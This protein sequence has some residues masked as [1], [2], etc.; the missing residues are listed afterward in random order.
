MVPYIDTGDN[1]AFAFFLHSSVVQNFMFKKWIKGKEFILTYSYLHW[2]TIPLYYD[3]TVPAQAGT[4]IFIFLKVFLLTISPN[5]LK[6]IISSSIT[7]FWWFLAFSG[8]GS[9]LYFDIGYDNHIQMDNID[10]IRSYFIS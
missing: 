10:F 1:V 7:S 6:L 2:D 8:R 3:F 5:A 4:A 9:W